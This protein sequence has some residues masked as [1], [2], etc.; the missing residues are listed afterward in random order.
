M[1]F[2]E[3]GKPRG[4]RGRLWTVVVGYKINIYNFLPTFPTAPTSIFFLACET[5][6][7]LGTQFFFIRSQKD[8]FNEV[9]AVGK[10]GRWPQIFLYYLPL[11]QNRGRFSTFRGREVFR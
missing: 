3:F 2:S 10:V 9:G 6:K 11:A 1:E 7:K 4:R 5:T 8:E